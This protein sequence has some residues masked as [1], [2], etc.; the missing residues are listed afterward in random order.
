MFISEK[1][2]ERVVFFKIYFFSVLIGIV[3]VANLASNC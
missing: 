2:L 3:Q 1:L